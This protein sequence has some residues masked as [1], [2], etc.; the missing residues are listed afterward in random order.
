M[1]AA[2][3]SDDTNRGSTPVPSKAAAAARKVKRDAEELEG[4]VEEIPRPFTSHTIIANLADAEESLAESVQELA[5]WHGQASDGTHF[6]ESGGKGPGR[7]S[8]GGRKTRRSSGTG[9]RTQT[10]A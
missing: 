9:T 7:H 1:A 6:A 3:G 2:P 5:I 4:A 8:R 10:Q